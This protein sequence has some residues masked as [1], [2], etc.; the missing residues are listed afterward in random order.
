M[1]PRPFEPDDSAYLLGALSRREPEAALGAPSAG[2]AATAGGEYGFFGAT[3]GRSMKVEAFR[4][5][6]QI[7]GTGL[8]AR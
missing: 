8:L 4:P 1:T 5:A 7:S 3:P 2:H 6:S